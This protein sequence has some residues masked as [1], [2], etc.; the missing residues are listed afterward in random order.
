[1]AL[2]GRQP[3]RGGLP[4]GCSVEGRMVTTGG[5]GFSF[6]PE[7]GIGWAHREILWRGDTLAFEAYEA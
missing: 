4:P 7:Q 5:P 6:G 1:M 3:A 2:M